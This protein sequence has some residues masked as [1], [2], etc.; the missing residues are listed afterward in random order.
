MTLMIVKISRRMM[1]R[2]M[3]CKEINTLVLEPS[4]S[5]NNKYLITQLC[6]RA[7]IAKT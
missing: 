4:I 7:D 2:W 5:D 6:K 1:K 3:K